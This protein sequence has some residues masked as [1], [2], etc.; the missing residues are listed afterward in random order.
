MVSAL[1]NKVRGQTTP[2]LEVLD[3]MLTYDAARIA[4]Y[5]GGE[6]ARKRVLALAVHMYDDDVIAQTMQEIEKEDS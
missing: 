5:Y 2:P 1:L 3:R 6:V 4:K